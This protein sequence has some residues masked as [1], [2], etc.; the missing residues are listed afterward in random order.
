MV[1][2]PKS[3]VHIYSNYQSEKSRKSSTS[4]GS[5]SDSISKRALEAFWTHYTGLLEDHGDPE[6]Y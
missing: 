3:E 2:L 6:W 1:T 5:Y 4:T